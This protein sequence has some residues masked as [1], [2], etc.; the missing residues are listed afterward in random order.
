MTMSFVFARLFCLRTTPHI[1]II[2]FKCKIIFTPADPHNKP[3]GV[4]A[5]N[6]TSSC[7]GVT[8]A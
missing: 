2:S 5:G 1:N 4:K 3:G 6:I 7:K 8:M